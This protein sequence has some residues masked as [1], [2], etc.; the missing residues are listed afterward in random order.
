MQQRGRCK[1][2]PAGSNKVGSE[3]Y[4]G[5]EKFL[6]EI[7]FVIKTRQSHI[8]PPHVRLDIGPTEEAGWTGHTPP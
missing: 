8:S 1:Q 3:D 7:S 5:Y 6:P 4:E 2:E